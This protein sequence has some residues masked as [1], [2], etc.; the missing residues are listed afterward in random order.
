MVAK[1]DVAYAWTAAACFRE[2]SGTTLC[3]C[4]LTFLT[5]EALV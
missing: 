3:T 1:P 4:E 5:V 2:V